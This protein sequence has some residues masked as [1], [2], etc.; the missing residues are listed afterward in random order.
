MGTGSA[1][2]RNGPGTPGPGV[3][4]SCL[5]GQDLA[6]G[7]L[8]APAQP[9]LVSALPCSAGQDHDRLG[10]GLRPALARDMVRFM[11]AAFR[12]ALPADFGAPPWLADFWRPGVPAYAWPMGR[13]RAH[14]I[15]Q[16][17]V[18]EPGQALAVSEAAL[19]DVLTAPA[20]GNDGLPR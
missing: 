4:S 6:A 8:A 13:H 15:G 14:A 17:F 7:T 1:K 10:A 19:V 20:G 5:A 3:G 11:L 18:T 9:G 16:G 12:L 2:S